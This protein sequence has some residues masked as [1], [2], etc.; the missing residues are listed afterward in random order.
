MTRA[1]L[2]FCTA[3]LLAVAIPSLS[4]AQD[5]S[6]Q[7]TD[8]EAAQQQFEDF[9]QKM[10]EFAS[11]M[12]L[13]TKDRQAAEQ[14]RQ[15]RMKDAEWLAATRKGLTDAGYPAAAVAK[16]PPEQYATIDAFLADPARVWAMWRELGGQ[17]A[18]AEPNAAH[19]AIARLEALG[20]IEAVVTQNIDNLHERAGS[21]RVTSRCSLTGSF[22]SSARFERDCST[23][24]MRSES[25]TEDTSGFV[26][27][28]AWLAKYSASSAPFSMPAG[29][30]QRM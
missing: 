15:A 4:S 5:G 21:K 18:E 24:R 23:P 29:L 30:S 8:Q 6:T 20:C 12:E 26:T 16:Y 27:T 17:L 9:V 10:K 28:I 13:E 3:A 1:R 19:R 11:I 25:R 14:W 7:A 22:F 2:L